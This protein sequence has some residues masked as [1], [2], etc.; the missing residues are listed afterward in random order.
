MRTICP[1]IFS[2]L[3]FLAT[4]SEMGVAY[5]AL[6]ILSAFLTFSQQILTN[7]TFLE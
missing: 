1:K 4:M 3:D 7:T 6:K 2:K 5:S